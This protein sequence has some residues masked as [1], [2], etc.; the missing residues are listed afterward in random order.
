MVKVLRRVR[1][2]HLIREKEREDIRLLVFRHRQFS[3]PIPHLLDR[4]AEE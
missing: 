3:P 2:S 1:L 4:E